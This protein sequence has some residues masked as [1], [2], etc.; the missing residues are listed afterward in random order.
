MYTEDLTRGLRVSERIEA[1]IVG[2]HRG[3][4]SDPAGPFGGM[5][6][7]GL[8]RGGV[9]EGVKEFCETE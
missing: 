8:G 2:P 6:Q 3:A 5:R 9:S 7:S 1:G 4:V